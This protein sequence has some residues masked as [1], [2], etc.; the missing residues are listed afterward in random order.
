MEVKTAAVIPDFFLLFQF[1]FWKDCLLYL[2]KQ[3]GPFICVSPNLI[4]FHLV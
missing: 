3:G 1:V 2:N 4:W